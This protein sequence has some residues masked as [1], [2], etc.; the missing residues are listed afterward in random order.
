MIIRLT[1]TRKIEFLI[2]R[3]NGI[4]HFYQIYLLKYPTLIQIFFESNT[5][6]KQTFLSKADEKL[7][8]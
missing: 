4:Q 5:M 7:K 3:K 1:F 2:S 8:Y 6:L